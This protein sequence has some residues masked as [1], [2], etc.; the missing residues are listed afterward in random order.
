M[1]WMRRLLSA[2]RLEGELDREIAYHVERRTADLIGEGW[3]AAQ[4]ARQ[5]R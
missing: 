1:G 2:K 4:A 3:D 5:A